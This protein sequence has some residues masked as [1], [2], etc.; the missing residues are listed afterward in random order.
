VPL[1]HGLRQL[2]RSSQRRAGVVVGVAAEV[3][4]V[5]G[6]GRARGILA[7]ASRQTSVGSPSRGKTTAS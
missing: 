6:P 3:A 5:V 1:R 7:D 2:D 4:D